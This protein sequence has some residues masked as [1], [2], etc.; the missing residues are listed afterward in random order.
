MVAFIKLTTLDDQEA[1]FRV[2]SIIGFI[3]GDN[4]TE[5]RFVGYTVALVKEDTDYIF[6]KIDEASNKGSAE[7]NV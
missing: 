3:K 1:W 7:L 6:S 2:D 5:V 4:V